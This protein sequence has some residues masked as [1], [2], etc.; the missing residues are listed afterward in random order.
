MQPMMQEMLSTVKNTSNFPEASPCSMSSIDSTKKHMLT[1]RQ[2][3]MMEKEALMNFDPK[4]IRN[5]PRVISKM[6]SLDISQLM[7][8]SEHPSF[9]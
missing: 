8:I 6:L 5:V 3:I 1:T 4:K 7:L 9:P 2:K